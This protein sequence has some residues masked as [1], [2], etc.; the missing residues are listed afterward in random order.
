MMRTMWGDHDRFIDTYFTAYPGNYFTGDGCRRDEDGYYWITGR[1]DDVINVSGHRLGTMEVES[2][3]VA[4][5]AVVE[6]V[7]AA[8]RDAGA[9]LSMGDSPGGAL[10]GIERLW[11]NTGF[12]ELSER[13]G[14]PL[15]NFEASSSRSSDQVIASP[16]PTKSV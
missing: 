6:A 4:H 16:P 13:T 11:R 12:K 9:E 5:P 14:V 15:V 7:I 8:A 1:V 10:R 3:L 2:T